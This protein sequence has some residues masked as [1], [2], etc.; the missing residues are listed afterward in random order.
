MQILEEVLKVLID[1][2]LTNEPSKMHVYKNNIEFSGSQL[3]NLGYSPSAKNIDTIQSL[4]RPK[5]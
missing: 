5:T 1:N 4:D 3:N 2:N